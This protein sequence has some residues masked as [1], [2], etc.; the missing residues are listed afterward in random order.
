[1]AVTKGG[2][3]TTEISA[4]LTDGGVIDTYWT[5]GADTLASV[6]GLPDGSIAPGADPVYGSEIQAST[7]TKAVALTKM[8]PGGPLPDLSAPHP[9]G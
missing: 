5:N 8:H 2:K 1:M 4:Q 6:D 7:L 3:T 9:R